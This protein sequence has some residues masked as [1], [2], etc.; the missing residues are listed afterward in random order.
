VIEPGHVR[1][2]LTELSVVE[3][4]I[5]A[6]KVLTSTAASQGVRANDFDWTIEGELVWI[7]WVCAKDRKNPDGGCGCGRSFSGLSSHRA[8]T[9]A[10]VRDLP[11]TRD[12]VLTAL[13]GYLE[14]A[15][16]GTFEPSELV[17]E[18]DELLAIVSE[19][20]VGTIIERRLDLLQPRRHS[21]ID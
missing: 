19:W 20:D 12:D 1:A 6:M 3:Y 10:Q 11:F 21:S 4:R 13:T 16:Y 7:G 2:G 18:V 9:T 8:T 15:G 5:G 17:D 14:S